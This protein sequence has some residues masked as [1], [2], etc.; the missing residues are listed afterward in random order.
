MESKQVHMG[1]MLVR[2]LSLNVS[3]YRSVKDLGTYLEEQGVI[4]ITDI[5]TRE[6]TRRL[7]ETGC[8]NGVLTTDASLSD[9]EL[10]AKAKAY[11]IVG[12]DLIS[13]VTCKEPYEWKETTAEWEFSN[14]AKANKDSFN[15]VVYDFGVKHNILRR[16]ASFGCKLT[17]VP[18]SYPAIR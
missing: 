7:R 12:K 16:L 9:A 10:V 5:D 13:E 1:A 4:G 2:N 15:V 17:I 14:E 6:I 3:N 18:A 11:N 8:L